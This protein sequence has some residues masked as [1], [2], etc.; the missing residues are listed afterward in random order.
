MTSEIWLHT[1]QDVVMRKV[2]GTVTGGVLMSLIA[3]SVCGDPLIPSGPANAVAVKKQNSLI[4]RTFSERG[5]NAFG[6][7]LVSV[8]FSPYS[9]SVVAV[10]FVSVG[11]DYGSSTILPDIAIEGAGD[12]A[13]QKGDGFEIAYVNC[14]TQTYSALDYPST[15]DLSSAERSWFVRGEANKWSADASIADNSKWALDLPGSSRVDLATFF[16]DLCDATY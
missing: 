6:S 7:G 13:I 12:G 4:G 1:Q 10:Y 11:V 16:S 2:I 15:D 5:G 14:K 9:R 8:G 3:S